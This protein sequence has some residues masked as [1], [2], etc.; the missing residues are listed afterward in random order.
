MAFVN[1]LSD[2]V[3]QPGMTVSIVHGSARVKLEFAGRFSGGE[4]KGPNIYKK[5]SPALAEQAC[6]SPGISNLEN[7]RREFEGR[8]RSAP[9]FFR[10]E[11]L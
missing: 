8:I 2:T 3:C 6:C 1:A 4:D 10:L 11:D 5:Q 9:V 7:G